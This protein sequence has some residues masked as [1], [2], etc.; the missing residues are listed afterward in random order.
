MTFRPWLSSRRILIAV[1][2]VAI[3]LP[4]TLLA[5]PPDGAS[6][7]YMIEFKQFPGAAAAVR[8]A[9]GSVVHE[10]P[11]MNVV[12]AHLP[13]RAFEALS[14]NPNVA[15]IAED[16]KRY[17]MAQST[18]Y[19]IPMVQADLL[20]DASAA[21][22]KV[23]IIDSGFYTGHEDLTGNSV[24]GTNNS[25]TGNW[26]QD[27]CGHGTHV[28]GTISAIS[29][30]TG[31]VGVLP[32]GKVALHIVKVF[33]DD[34]AW[35]YS[36]DLIAA[37]DT[38]RNAGAN[39]VSMS[40]GGGK[41]IGPWEQNAFDSAWSAGVLSIAAAGNDG[42]T[43]LSYP[44]S[45]SSVV[46]VAALDENKL[47]A[48]FSQKNSA[49]E[50][51]AP[52]VAVNSTVPFLESNSLSISGGPSYA[53]G[54]ID[55]SPRTS[56]A[57]GGLVDGG[58]C[59]SV[60]AWSGKVVLCQRGTI[61]FRDKV[62]N[63]A[64]GG[65]VAAIIYN[66]VSGDFLGT[67]DDG[68]GTTCTRPAISLSMENGTA[69]KN[70]LG[71]SSTVVSQ[72]TQPASGY[73]AWNGTSMATPHVS[74]VAALVWSYNTAWSNSQVRT[75]LQATAQDLGAAGR[76]NSYGYGLVQ[77]RAALCYLNPNAT[78]CGGGTP[79]NNP[80]SAS[81]SYSTSGLTASFTDSSTDSD[82]SIASWAWN[83]GDGSTSTAQNPSR[84]YAAGGTYTVTLTVTDNAGATGTT[85]Q[86][87]TVS[88]GQTG[89]ISLTV[90]GYKVKGVQTAD[91][92]WGGAT[93]T[94]VDIFRNG[95]KIVTTANDGAHTDNI[96][97]KGGGTHTY[98]V[99][100]AGTSTCSPDVTVSF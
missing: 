43:N 49:V 35:S 44:A 21:N 31:V 17:P 41:G 63:A 8:G 7:R 90:T 19:G 64:A 79:T 52:G 29:N 1:L 66:N 99:C 95:S 36:S 76:D 5:A 50:L 42:T 83:F 93:S 54:H 26:Y 10:F 75:A 48:D 81:F 14:G 4:A 13:A 47:V 94:S 89:G 30:T 59:D 71:T 98:R 77:A 22:R 70:Y 9:G 85:S 72:I 32:N 74:G 38:C 61:S 27:K 92:A 88:S 57:T 60:G 55:G 12:A 18:P 51:A 96:G 3:F 68:T 97:L 58:I 67:C 2:A 33:G 91:L 24:N 20:S 65:A 82:G 11:A 80:P 69:A 15:L 73:E 40:L 28:A 86:S 39:V 16:P 23:C 78:E 62:Q 56:G 53:G 87:V 37:L 100:E 25:G 46:S 45:Y 34:C 84:T 6:G